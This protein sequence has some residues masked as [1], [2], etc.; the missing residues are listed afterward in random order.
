MA[1]LTDTYNLL[2]VEQNNLL[3][4]TNFMFQSVK[5][6]R[7][8]SPVSIIIFI[9]LSGFNKVHDDEKRYTIIEWKVYNVRSFTL[10]RQNHLNT[11]E[12]Y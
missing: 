6:A 12:S 10:K 11:W 4:L 1:A 3:L 5:I 9:Y 8:L 2:W 7:I